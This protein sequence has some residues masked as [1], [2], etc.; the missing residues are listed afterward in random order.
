MRTA[1]V[2]RR[3]M[4]TG[5]AASALAAPMRAYGQSDALVGGS[6]EDQT[7]RLQQA[8][9]DAARAGR[10]LDLPGGT[11]LVEALSPPSGL[12][13]RGVPGHTTLIARNGGPALSLDNGEDIV[14]DDITFRAA[15][16]GSSAGLVTLNAASGIRLRGCD[17]AQSALGLDA[18]ASEALITDCRFGNLSD[19]AIHS[20][21]GLGLTITQ[22][23]IAD[24]GNAG[25]RIWRSANGTDPTII[26]NNRIERIDWRGGGNGQ[27][28]NGVN[29]FR[30]DGA[31]IANNHIADC[32]FT[33]VR[34]NGSRNAQVSGNL[35]R[36]SGEVAIFSEFEFSGSVIANNIVDGA[37][38]GI[39][40]T[41]LDAGGQ[42]A[43]CTGNIVRNIAPRSEVNPDT[44]PYGIYAE[45]ETV[46][47]GNTVQNIPGIGLAAG[48]GSYLRNVV[49]T[50]NVANDIDIGIGVSVVEGAGAV[51]IAD[52]II[53]GASQHAVAGLAWREV[54]EPDLLANASRFPNVS[55]GENR[56][57]TATQLS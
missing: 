4:L 46:I 26:S 13:L 36:D 57:G 1:A 12:V 41:N 51:H 31:I 11:F 5:L 17:F 25:I 40:I 54:V 55:L 23:R 47:S 18:F 28:G 14:I 30:A 22:C 21:D 3:Q 29:V 33:A 56:V 27:N 43:V 10:P 52:N 50:G 2:N 9:L 42:L 15:D 39:S 16:P 38:A 32:A 24:C 8:M 6:G 7:L 48:F 35:C 34:L 44:T 49:I 20:M 19:A 37:A 45:A 53:S